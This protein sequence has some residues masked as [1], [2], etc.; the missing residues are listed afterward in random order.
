MLS[1]ERPTKGIFSL[2]LKW[3]G[4]SG[5][6]KNEPWI[7]QTSGKYRI[8]GISPG[9]GTLECTYYSIDNQQSVL[10]ESIPI[11]LS[12]DQVFHRDFTVTPEA[13]QP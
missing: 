3:D 7:D 13:Q 8:E 1:Q 11:T 6:E 2:N 5:A 10:L 9:H 4:P 12:K